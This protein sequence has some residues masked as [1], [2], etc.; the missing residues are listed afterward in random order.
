MDERAALVGAKLVVRDLTPEPGCEV[1]LDVPL[2]G[3]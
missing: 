2:E 1:R 3:V